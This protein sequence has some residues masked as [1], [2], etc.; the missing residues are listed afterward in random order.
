MSI[1]IR[2]EAMYMPLPMGVMCISVLKGKTDYSVPISDV[3]LS[4]TDL[5]VLRQQKKGCIKGLVI[6]LPDP[7]NVV[8]NIEVASW[9]DCAC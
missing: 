8:G 3:K 4:Q 9:N 6:Q 2:R 5:M 7:E 1:R